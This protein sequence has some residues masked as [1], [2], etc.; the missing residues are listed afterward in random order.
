MLRIGVRLLRRKP[1]G[2]EER[3]MPALFGPTHRR[4]IQNL[5]RESR[6]EKRVL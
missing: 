5:Y 2:R 4:L 3:T 6:G 1:R